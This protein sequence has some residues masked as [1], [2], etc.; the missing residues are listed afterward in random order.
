MTAGKDD[1]DDWTG[2]PAPGRD[3]RV[4]P[5]PAL[6]VETIKGVE[7]L[8]NQFGVAH[9]LSVPSVL[10]EALFGQSDL[11]AGR[12]ILPLKTY[13]LLDAA[14]VPGLPEMLETSGPEHTCLFQGAAAEDLSDVAP[15]LVRL[16][17]GHRLTRNLFTRG[18]APWA[19]WDAKVGLF[20]RS[21]SS[22][23]DLRR[24]LRK[25]TRVRNNA[26]RTVFFRF[27]D[28]GVLDCLAR[29]HRDA[30]TQANSIIP[31][32]VGNTEIF[33]P[34]PEESAFLR[35]KWGDSD[36]VVRR[37]PS[38]TRR[39][40]E[41]LE[42]AKW[43]RFCRKVHGALAEEKPSPPNFDA[44]LAACDLAF[45]LGYRKEKSLFLIARA[46]IF[47]PVRTSLV[48]SESTTFF[49][50]EISLAC[51]IDALVYKTDKD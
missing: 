45:R 43:L 41:C 36:T 8:G 46:H 4:A 33:V 24:H 9:P 25:F 35:L 3:V 51:A 50:D 10:R 23:D 40:M 15:W 12:S 39:D 6:C 7:P 17:E 48:H 32:L 44:V 20:V 30:P 37:V 26:G 14:K 5:V 31:L 11:I 38:L 29:G 42:G 27:W 2:W 1:Q 34:L 47:D 16:E 28:A 21:Q 13:A 19:M 18:N 49:K 22:L